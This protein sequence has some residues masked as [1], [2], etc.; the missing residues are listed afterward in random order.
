LPLAPQLIIMFLYSQS[1][2]LVQK[3]KI[4]VNWENRRRTKH[5]GL[6][7]PTWFF[8]LKQTKLLPKT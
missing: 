2:N 3:E 7:L 6:T 8:F 1:T 5:F 4:R